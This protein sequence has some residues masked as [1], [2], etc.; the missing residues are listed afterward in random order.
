MVTD[1][2]CHQNV[3]L[4]APTSRYTAGMLNPTPS[5]ITPPPPAPPA[6]AQGDSAEFAWPHWS[7]EDE[8]RYAQ[9]PAATRHLLSAFYRR[10][11]ALLAAPTAPERESRLAW[12]EM[13][14]HFLDDSAQAS[15]YC[16]LATQQHAHEHSHYTEEM[17]ELD[18]HIQHAVDLVQDRLD[19]EARHQWHELRASGNFNLIAVEMVQQSLIQRAHEIIN[20]VLQHTANEAPLHRQAKADDRALAHHETALQSWS[21]A[22]NYGHHAQRHG[23]MATL[24]PLEPWGK[25]T[26]ILLR[27]KI[28]RAVHRRAKPPRAGTPWGQYVRPSAPSTTPTPPADNSE[29]ALFTLTIA[30]P[31]QMDDATFRVWLESNEERV[32]HHLLDPQGLV[33]AR[34]DQ[35]RVVNE[36]V[37]TPDWANDDTGHAKIT[38]E[39]TDPD[40]AHSLGQKIDAT[41]E[42]SNNR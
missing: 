3:T 21:H 29:P 17:L 27:A 10:A 14:L 12:A 11:G 40:L 33:P 34:N 9:D 37:S 23:G 6:D 28:E 4:A 1:G 7:R 38:L 20:E 35:F 22:L 41:K 19:A 42:I 26:H 18:G 15:R 13:A 36:G 32:I 8:I 25:S 5:P 2:N 39:I 16:S 24:M 31:P 30:K